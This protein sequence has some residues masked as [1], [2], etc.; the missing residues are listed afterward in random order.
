MYKSCKNIEKISGMRNQDI[1]NKNINLKWE[2]A[3]NLVLILIGFIF[4]STNIQ[5]QGIFNTN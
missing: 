1:H 3:I 2:I 4:Y 5:L